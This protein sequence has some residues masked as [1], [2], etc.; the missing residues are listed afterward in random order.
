MVAIEANAY[1]QQYQQQQQKCNVRHDASRIRKDERQFHREGSL[2]QG[3]Q[4]EG[5][6]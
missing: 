5:S 6:K 1:Q 3:R 4:E 2:N